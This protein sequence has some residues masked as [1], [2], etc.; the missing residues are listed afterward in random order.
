MTTERKIIVVGHKNPDT[1]S[2]CSAIAYAY[3]KNKTTEGAFEARRAGEIN[4]ETRFVLDR[5]GVPIPE[6]IDDVGTQVREMEI[7][8]TPGISKEATIQTAWDQMNRTGAVTQPVIENGRV[9]GLRRSIE[10]EE[11]EQ[12]YALTREK[13]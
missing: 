6:Y 13:E 11:K 7:R 8:T 1:D 10:K 9:I 2:I 5:F 4:A 12:G 3:F